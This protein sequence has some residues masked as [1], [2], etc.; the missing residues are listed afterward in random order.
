MHK[1][2]QFSK[3]SELHIQTTEIAEFRRLCLR[4]L[5]AEAR[6]GVQYL[7]IKIKGL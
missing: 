3:I 1:I 4:G 7:I 2:N 5:Q 6:R